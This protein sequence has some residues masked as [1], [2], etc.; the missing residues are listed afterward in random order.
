MISAAA[1]AGIGR[2]VAAIPLRVGLVLAMVVLVGIVLAASGFAVTS[3]LSKSLTARTDEQLADA[4]HDWARPRPMKRIDTPSGPR[5]APA[6]MPTPPQAVPLGGEQPHR[7]YELR[8]LPDGE[9]YLESKE[10]SAP[11]LSELDG[12]GPATVDSIDGGST[13]WRVLTVA[14]DYGSTVIALPLTDNRDTVARLTLFEIVTGSAALLLLAVAGYFV[15][16]RSLRPLR[17]VEET[18]A[19]IAAGDLHRRVPMRGVETE[20]DHLARSVNAMLTRIQHG[21][22]ATEASEEA[23]RQSE[24]NM[25]RF[26]ADASHELRTPLTTIR[27]F[28]ELYR[29][30]ASRDPRQVLERIEA[31]AARM[32]V[33]VEDLLMLARLDA[34]RP[35]QQAPVDLLSLAGEVV[36]SARAMAEQ[37]HPIALDI[38]PGVGTLEVRGDADRLRQ[39]LMNLVGNAISHTPPGT[40]ITVRLTPAAEQVRID[41]AD[42]GPGLSREAAGRVFERFYRTD[43]SRT[44]ASGGTGLGLSIVR[45][46]VRAHGGTVGVT[47]ELGHGATFTVV[48]PRGAD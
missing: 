24:A 30:G 28:A 18:A 40:P 7:F 21:V 14:N 34:Q 8:S 33:L 9:I 6:D 16:R 15:V 3:A 13:R 36:H 26:V 46:L 48:L 1:R 32:G 22:A 35:L 23:A 11:D 41:V 10:K 45:S 47:S 37:A 29:Q 2:R 38:A 44:R 43:S 19:A 4:A 12:P 25:R 42:T 20:V 5:L 27:G 31:E 17:Q 39:V